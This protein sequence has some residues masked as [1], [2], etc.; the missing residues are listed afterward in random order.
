MCAHTQSSYTIT[1]K[2]IKFSQTAHLC[3]TNIQMKDWNIFSIPKAFFMFSFY[4]YVSF[5][6]ITILTVTQI[7][8]PTF[9]F[10]VNRM[11]NSVCKF[12]LCDWLLFT[13]G[14]ICG[15][16][17]IVANSCTLLIFIPALYSIR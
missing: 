12:S 9:A 11:K 13:Q 14:C 8:L 7:I 4:L 6:L 3:V 17:Y 10:Y 5:R 2:L 1:L 16:I 15:N